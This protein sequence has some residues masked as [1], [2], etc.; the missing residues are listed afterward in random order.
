MFLCR[1]SCENA[2]HENTFVSK[3]TTYFRNFLHEIHSLGSIFREI[4][5]NEMQKYVP[6][7]LFLNLYFDKKYETIMDILS[8]RLLKPCRKALVITL[9]YIVFERI[10][11]FQYTHIF[12]YLELSNGV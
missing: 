3:L 5:E 1:V 9:S 6:P 7:L 2:E 10:A 12:I 4:M 8:R 11:F